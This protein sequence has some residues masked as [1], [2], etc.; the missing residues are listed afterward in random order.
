MLNRTIEKARRFGWQ[1]WHVPAPMRSTREG[2]WVGARE[3]AGLP[4]LVMIHVDKRRMILAEIKG[5]GGKLSDKQVEFLSAAR[6][7][8]E[9]IDDYLLGNES[10]VA[11]YAWFPKDEPIIEQ[12]LRTGLLI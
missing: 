11:V 4:D 7:I 3:G 6:T 2:K 9:E 12:I 1:V 10:I 5:D 8:A